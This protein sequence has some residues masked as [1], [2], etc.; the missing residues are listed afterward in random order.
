MIQQT[1]GRE[2]RGQIGSLEEM[3]LLKEQNNKDGIKVM[4]KQM[5]GR[6]RKM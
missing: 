5:R 6:K 3:K 4:R 1:N 2:T